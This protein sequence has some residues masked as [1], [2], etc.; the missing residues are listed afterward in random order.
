[1]NVYGKERGFLMTVGASAEIAK[2]C[3]GEKLENLSKVFGEGAGD[4]ASLETTAKLIVALN[5]GYEEN[6]H[7]TDPSH[8]AQP[9]TVPEVLSLTVDDFRQLQSEAVAAMLPK[10]EIESEPVKK[11]TV[12]PT[13]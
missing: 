1:M 12:E 6:L 4:A 10:R 7:F 5:K 13:T 2:L 11:N 3:P 8:P 9:L